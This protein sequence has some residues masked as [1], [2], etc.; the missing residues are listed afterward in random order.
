MQKMRSAM[1][2]LAVPFAAILVL[3]PATTLASFNLTV[4]HVNDIHVRL[5]ETNKYSGVCKDND[6]GRQ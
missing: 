1:Q 2:H 5:E 3:L 6:K 4:A